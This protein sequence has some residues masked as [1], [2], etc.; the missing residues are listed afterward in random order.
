VHKDIRWFVSAVS[1][2]DGTVNDILSN[3]DGTGLPAW[4]PD[5]NSFVLPIGMRNEDRMQLFVV[6]YPN[7][8]ISR[9]TNDLSDYRPT[10]SIT[11]DGQYLVALGR[12]RD[13]HVWIAPQGQTAQ[14]HQLTSGDNADFSVAPGP[15]GKILFR[16]HGIDVFAMNADGS[17]RAALVPDA[18]AIFSISACSDRYIVFDRYLNNKLELWR[19]DADGSNA[20]KLADDVRDSRCSPDGTWVLFATATKLFRI[21]VAGGTPTEIPTAAADIGIAR[22]SPDGKWLA[23]QYAQGRPIP[24]DKFSIMPLGG[25]PATNTMVWPRNAR[26]LEW[27]PDGKGMQFSL[28]QNGADNIWEIPIAGGAPKQI[29]N[30]SSDLIFDF[31]WTR[32]G[33]TLLM[34][35]GTV[36]RDV[37]LLSNF[38]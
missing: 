36:N 26:G 31:Q 22:I 38:R 3:S 6:S 1:V 4:L 29:T 24:T 16:S 35:R 20:I 7:G 14:A 18:N 8:E 15:F 5:G 33:K 32:D 17:Q 19:A 10:I 27:A 23:L 28:R 30:F 9:M 2:A 13:A 34:S 21:P 25:G 37:I 12:R 11:R